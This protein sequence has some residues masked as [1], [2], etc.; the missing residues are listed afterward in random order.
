M[1]ERFLPERPNLDQLRTQAKELLRAAKVG[2]PAAVR[3]LEAV[4][5]RLTLASAQLALAREH[6][7]ASWTRLNVEV[8]RKAALARGD[9]RLLAELVTRHPELAAEGVSS[10]FSPD[11]ADSPLSYIAVARFHGSSTTT[12]R[13]RAGRG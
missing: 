1:P 11:P 9:V 7:F 3:R 4:T 5:G 12:A 6:G 10:C 2:E 8:E 13:R